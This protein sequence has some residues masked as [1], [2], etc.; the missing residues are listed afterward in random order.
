MNSKQTKRANKQKTS[1]DVRISCEK[2]SDARRQILNYNSIQQ[3][4]ELQ[5]FKLVHRQTSRRQLRL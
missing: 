1:I 3:K 4:L 2:F 5:K